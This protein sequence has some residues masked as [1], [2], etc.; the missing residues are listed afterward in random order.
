MADYPTPSPRRNGNGALLVFIVIAVFMVI[1][2]GALSV[3]QTVQE[4]TCG[5]YSCTV[6][7][8]PVTATYSP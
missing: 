2:G 3:S 4:T 7:N 8:L 6:T 1:G 5:A